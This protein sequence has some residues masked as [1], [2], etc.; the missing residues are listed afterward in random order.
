MRRRILN[1]II[2]MPL[3]TAPIQ[4]NEK[5]FWHA[6]NILLT[7]VVTLLFIAILL[8]LRW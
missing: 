7:S 4:T 3:H 1:L 8:L 5:N 2:A 6:H